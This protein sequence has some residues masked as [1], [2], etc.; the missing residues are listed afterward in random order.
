MHDPRTS[1]ALRTLAQLTGD[2]P[3]RRWD[4]SLSRLDDA[5]RLSLGRAITDVVGF[6]PFG[7][8][9]H[10]LALFVEPDPPVGPQPAALDA[11]G[12]LLV[13]AWLRDRG[14]HVLVGLDAFAPRLLLAPVA[15]L[16]GLGDVLAGGIR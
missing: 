2:P 16:D 3:Q 13:P 9:W 10:H 1:P 4:W 8:R 11:R 6:G 15:V 5:G 12:R 14:R 7:L